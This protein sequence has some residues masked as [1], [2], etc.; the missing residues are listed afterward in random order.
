[1]DLRD[2][3]VQ[4]I[5]LPVLYSIKFARAFRLLSERIRELAIYNHAPAVIIPFETLYWPSVYNLKGSTAMVYHY[6][7]WGLTEL[8]HH[9][10]Q[11]T[12]SLVAAASAETRTMLFQHTFMMPV[13]LSHSLARRHL[14]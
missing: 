2:F 11:H 6:I 1:M 7:I 8:L 14:P 13:V 9:E 5:I 3:S 10:G 4:I 12:Q